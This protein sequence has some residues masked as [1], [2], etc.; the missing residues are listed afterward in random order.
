MTKVILVTHFY[1][2]H[3]GGVEI[4]AY[5]TAKI[6]A[7]SGNFQ[8]AWCAADCDKPPENEYF[9]DYKPLNSTNIIEKIL[10]FPY[11]IISPLEKL[12]LWGVLKKT[13]VVHIHDFIYHS[14]LMAFFL[15]KMM[16]KK[17][18]LTQHIGFIPYRNK[19]LR[20]VL[21]LINKTLGK[22]VISR[23]DSAIFISKSVMQYFSEICSRNEHFV[24]I[25]NPLDISIFK[26]VDESSRI[27]LRQK[28]NLSE[29][30][31]LFVGRFTEKKGLEIIKIVAEN[32]PDCTF[33]MA[34][35]GAINPKDWKLPN[36]HVLS[37]RK[38]SGI[39][40]LYSAADV[41]ILPSYGE[42]FPLVVQEGIACGID[43]IV[44]S[45]IVESEP[46]I[47]KFV[48]LVY[49][50]SEKIEYFISNIKEY[51]S[52]FKYNYDN[53]LS[54]YNFAIKKWSE[55]TIMQ[56]YKDIFN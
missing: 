29:F 24:H 41:L 56:D 19:V 4:A 3:R 43:L 1:P 26:P 37:D 18:I 28:L 47:R 34:G 36:I 9:F 10:P 5:N 45:E 54:K 12:K 51:L 7:E 33:I 30:T 31:F 23:C 22:F 2:A 42:G 52:N 21:T 25:P 14:N 6:L 11:P 13:D 46:D 53:R 44:S 55:E 35:H 50:P 32:F 48:N 27:E 39:S 15:A 38:G 20:Q 17:V 40:E 16:K 49:N 8:I